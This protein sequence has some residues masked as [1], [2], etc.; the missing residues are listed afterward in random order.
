MGWL[1]PIIVFPT[2]LLSSTPPAYVE[3]L[4][5]HELAH[6]ARH[7]YLLNLLQLA[8]D[9]LLFFN[10]AAWWLSA[11]VRT[12]RECCADAIAAREVGDPFV[13][14]R[15]LTAL[16]T[17]RAAPRPT[18]ASSGGDLMDRI[19]RLVTPARRGSW[20]ALVAALALALLVAGCL[21]S[22]PG[23]ESESEPQPDAP[24]TAALSA[25]PNSPEAPKWQLPAGIAPYQDLFHRAGCQHGVDPELLA[26]VALVE[27]NGDPTARSPMGA[28]G[29]MQLMPS[30][31]ERIA[32][33]RGLLDHSTSKLE[34]PSY[35]LDLAAWYLARQL[36]AFGQGAPEAV[37]I[38]RAAAAYNGG[39]ARLRRSMGGGDQ[40]SEETVRY[41]ARVLELWQDFRE[42]WDC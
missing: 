30:T 17:L 38:E 9:D 42:N 16:E 3:A 23:S 6:I 40:L 4:L 12:E 11:R 27:S 21:A 2:S 25:T 13:Y 36:D 20:P 1:R 8:I 29:L 15:A 32:V 24:A 34:D 35:N 5:A 37:A 26:A 19:T 14:A 33:E 39:P 31:A 7:D 22:L 18:L 28:V 41:K 10:P